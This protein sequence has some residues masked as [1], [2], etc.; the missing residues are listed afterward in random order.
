MKLDELVDI[1][2]VVIEHSQVPLR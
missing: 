1:G 2:L